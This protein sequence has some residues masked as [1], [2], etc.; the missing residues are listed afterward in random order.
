VPLES[1]AAT[2]ALLKEAG[3]REILIAE[4]ISKHQPTRQLYREYGLND[5]EAMPGVHLVALDEGPVVEVQ[6]AEGLLNRPFHVADRVLQCD[7]LVSL[8]GLKTHHQTGV[9]ISMKNLYAFFPNSEKSLWHRVDPDKAIVD[10]N[11]VRAPDF[12]IVDAFIAQEGLGPRRGRPV[13]LGIVF[14]GPDP[15]AVDCIGSMIMDVDPATIRHIHWAAEKGLGTDRLDEIAVTGVPLANVR[16][17]LQTNLEHINALLDGQARLLAADDACN[18]CIGVAVTALHLGIF[19]FGH[20]AADFRGLTL[21]IGD[22]PGMDGE[23]TL[24][25]SDHVR[26]AVPGE[27]FVPGDPPTVTAV[28]QAVCRIMGLADGSRVWF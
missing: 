6:P 4:D 5:L 21:C 23:R 28:W 18:G 26:S 15:V 22:V 2:C 27:R 11:L 9:T 3:A 1:I 10:L 13:E 16:R 19:R 14:A 12:S 25:V 7:R 8:T 20:T 24:W 17:H